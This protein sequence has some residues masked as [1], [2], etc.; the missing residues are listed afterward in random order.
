VS[1]LRLRPGHLQ[2]ST[3][4]FDD[5]T[6]R[7]ECSDLG[8]VLNKQKIILLEDHTSRSDFWLCTSLTAL[9]SISGMG[10]GLHVEPK[11]LIEEL[12]KAP[13]LSSLDEE[14]HDE[15]ICRR[16]WHYHWALSN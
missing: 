4:E 7:V 12:L 5:L 10:V 9:K 13:E 15:H 11:E 8:Y 3:N 1:W 6:K 14:A 16:V 2:Q